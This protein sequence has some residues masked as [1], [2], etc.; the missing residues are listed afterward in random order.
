M[1]GKS[2]LGFRQS[3]LFATGLVLSGGEPSTRRRRWMAESSLSIRWSTRPYVFT[4]PTNWVLPTPEAL[5]GRRAPAK[6]D[7]AMDVM[8][9]VASPASVRPTDSL[10]VISPAASSTA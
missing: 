6:R 2:G 1:F 4:T 8:V 5:E 7:Q 3:Y 9:A 10:D